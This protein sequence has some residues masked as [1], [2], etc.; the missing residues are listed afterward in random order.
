MNDNFELWSL[1]WHSLQ[2]SLANQV[3]PLDV[4]VHAPGSVSKAPAAP[5]SLSWLARAR[6]PVQVLARRG[7]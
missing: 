7:Q 6:A 3:Q 5:L 4:P 1:P 2:R